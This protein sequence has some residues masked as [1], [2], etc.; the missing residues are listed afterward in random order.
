[1]KS[2]LRLAG[3]IIRNDANEVLLLHRNTA[4]RTQWEIPGGKIEPGES[5]TEA[6]VRELKEELSVDVRV[7]RR[8]GSRDFEEDGFTMSY[9]WFLVE[10]V[11]GEAKIGEPQTFDDFRAFSQVALLKQAAVLSPNTR[12]F[13]E[14][15]VA[16]AFTLEA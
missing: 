14:A 7:V 5:A 1:M 3:C 4:K 12:N 2:Q 9:V 15:W 10:V 6:A 11:A 16:K 8:L 13:V